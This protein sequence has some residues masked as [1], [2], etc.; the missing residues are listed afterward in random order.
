MAPSRYKLSKGD[1][2]PEESESSENADTNPIKDVSEILKDN[3]ARQKAG[4]KPLDLQKPKSRRKRD[5]WLG[6]VVVNSLLVGSYFF[7]AGHP[8]TGVFSLSG[9]V[10][11]SAGFTWAM[12]GVISDY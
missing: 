2:H 4:E 8:L 9:I 3:Y 10:I 5:Y 11:F 6:M 12:W 1:S 7:W